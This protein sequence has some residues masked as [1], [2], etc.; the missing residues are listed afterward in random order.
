MNA[1][2]LARVLRLRG[3]LRR[4]ERWTRA[5]LEAY[6]ARALR[7]LRDFAFEKS[8]FYGRLHQGLTTR[9]LHELPVVSKA[10][11]MENFDEL[12]TDP[13]VRKRDVLAH[14][15]GL[16]GNELFQNEYWVSATS[17]S[18]GLRGVFLSDF[19]EWMTVRGSYARAQQW[20]G[21]A[22]GLT[23][24]VSIAVVLVAYASMLH[25][26]AQEQLAGRL[27][28]S[29]Q[30]IMAASEVLTDETRRRSKSAWGRVPF[31]VYAATETAAIASEC[32]L[33]R[34]HLY[35]DLVI[36][37]S[38]DERNLPVPPGVVGAKVLVTA[39]FSRTQPLIRYEM[40]DTLAL[41]A[42]PC[43]CGRVFALLDRVEG[44]QEDILTLQA[45]SGAATVTIHPNSFHKTL[46]DVPTT[47]W[48]VV[49]LADALEVRLLGLQSGFDVDA[50][51]QRVGAELA[52]QGAAPLRVVIRS[53]EQIDKTRLGKAPLVRRFAG[54]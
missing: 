19:D 12:V 38:V 17:G 14:L 29:P 42:E 27:H 2:V 46:E 15:E 31:N 33:H 6:Q 36:V 21:V 10:M 16:K 18:T 20:A 51:A 5:A 30:A 24:R 35:E 43:S 45:N 3:R 23:R 39:L 54:P 47:A 41:S 34:L 9:P 40:S 7:Q 50:L 49:Q 32:E 48:Q 26:L 44:R 1:N 52:A 13:R 53:V 37:E 28:I 25:V 22:V 11:L 4:R 8:P